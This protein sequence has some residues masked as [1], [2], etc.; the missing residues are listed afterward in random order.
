VAAQFSIQYSLASALM[1]RRLAVAD[2]A[3]EAVLDPAIG[4]L[5]R[6]VKVLVDESNKGKFAP[7]SLALATTRHG[8]LQREAPH[9]PGTPEHPLTPAEHRAKVL[10]CLGGGPRPLAGDAAAALI[11]RIENLGGVGDMRRFYDDLPAF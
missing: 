1:R 5:T 11:D 10:D 4:A 2:I 7:A 6:K 3:R 8:R 9:V